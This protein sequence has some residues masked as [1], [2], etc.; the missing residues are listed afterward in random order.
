MNTIIS[1]VIVT[2]SVTAFVY[3]ILRALGVTI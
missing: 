1:L 3:V 2:V